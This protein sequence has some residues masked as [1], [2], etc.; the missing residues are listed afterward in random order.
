M[1]QPLT[2][3]SI[4]FRLESIKQKQKMHSDSE[5]NMDTYIFSNTSVH[6]LNHKMPLTPHG[7]KAALSSM[8]PNNTFITLVV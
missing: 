2:K 3:S 5:G 6:I 1:F 4:H 8:K 7:V